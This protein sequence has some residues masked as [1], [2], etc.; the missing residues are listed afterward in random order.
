MEKFKNWSIVILFFI[1][2][3][4]MCPF[5]LVLRPFASYAKWVKKVFIDYDRN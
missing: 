3:I 5:Y 4:V 2:A 1:I